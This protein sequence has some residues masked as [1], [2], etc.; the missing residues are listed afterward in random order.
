MKVTAE[1]RNVLQSDQISKISVTGRYACTH[2]RVRIWWS[3]VQGYQ[4]TSIRFNFAVTQKLLKHLLHELLTWNSRANP[5]I[6]CGLFAGSRVLVCWRK[7]SKP[8]LADMTM[9]VKF[10]Y[11]H[12]A[13]LIQLPSRCRPST[14]ILLYRLAACFNRLFTSNWLR[15]RLLSVHTVYVYHILLMHDHGA[16]LPSRK[17]SSVNVE[18]CALVATMML[19]GL[20]NGEFE[21]DV[22]KSLKFFSLIIF[23]LD[24]RCTIYTDIGFY[25]DHDFPL[26]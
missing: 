18:T 20:V 14:D 5:L 23:P 1:I 12:S 3:C 4:L 2:V 15:S 13:S 11:Q 10:E 25:I 26:P 9:Q 16:S 21:C 7:F 24:K 22:T 6:F 19:R 17:W 8:S